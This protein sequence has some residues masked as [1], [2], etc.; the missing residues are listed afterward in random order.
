M[1]RFLTSHLRAKL[2]VL[3]LLPLLAGAALTAYLVYRQ[4][5]AVRALTPITANSHLA[6]RLDTLIHLLQAERGA[7]AFYQGEG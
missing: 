5:Q 3:V 6:H 1:I 2:M 4:N 7:T